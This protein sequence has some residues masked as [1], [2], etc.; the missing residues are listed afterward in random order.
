MQRNQDHEFVQRFFLTAEA[1]LYS[2]RN[3]DHEFVQRFFLTAE[4]ALYS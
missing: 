1:A 3:Q 2:E 4:A